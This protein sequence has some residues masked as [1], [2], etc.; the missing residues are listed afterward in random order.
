MRRLRW[1]SISSELMMC[2]GGVR[3]IMLLLLVARYLDNRCMYMARFL[4]L[5]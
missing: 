3:N 2:G 5:L 1:G 4:C